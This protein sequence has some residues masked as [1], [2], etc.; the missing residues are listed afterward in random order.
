MMRQQPVG[1]R[2]TTAAGQERASPLAVCT[3]A[4][5]ASR[6]VVGTHPVFLLGAGASVKSGIPGSADM[7]RV[8]LRWLVAGQRNL[9]PDDR[10]I[11]QSDIQEFLAQQ[12]WY[13][14][15]VNLAEF[16]PTVIALLDQPREM[17]RK[18]LLQMISQGTDPSQGYLD[19][20]ALMKRRIVTTV[21][22]P[23]FDELVKIAYG[24][25]GALVTMAN[26]EEYRALTT[27]PR[28]PQLVYLHG[29]AEYYL[30]KNRLE[31]VD[32]LDQVLVDRLLPI[33]RDHPL[34]VIGYRGA[35][36]SL[37]RDL[38]LENVD[39]ADGFKHGIYWCVRGT[40]L[41]QNALP[42]MV[43]ELAHRLGP[44]FTVVP[45]ADFDAVMAE[46]RTAW[47]EQ[48]DRSPGPWTIDRP[49]EDGRF[50]PLVLPLDQRA[51][52]KSDL[53]AIDWNWAA[54]LLAEYARSVHR[55]VPS[56]PDR[57]WCEQELLE[58][59][60]AVHQDGRLCL[61]NGG[62]MLLSRLAR[63]ASPGAW[64]QVWLPG[65]PPTAVDGTLFEQMEGVLEA[66]ESINRPV[67]VKGPRS[68]DQ[69]PYPEEAL[70]E[71]IANALVHRDYASPDPVRVKV[72]PTSVRIENPGGLD[73]SL[74]RRLMGRAYPPNP[75]APVPPDVLQRRIAHGDRGLSLTAYR[76]A[77]VA[78]VFWGIGLVDKLGSGLADAYEAMQVA[79]G[80][81]L[82]EVAG[83]NSSVIVTLTRMPARVDASTGTARPTTPRVRMHTNLLEILSIPRVVWSAPT[84]LRHFPDPGLNRA[85]RDWPRAVPY[86]GRFCTFSDLTDPA[87]PLRAVVD[88][89][90]IR[91]TETHL[92]A[93]D[94]GGRR[95]V[96]LLHETVFQHLARHGLVTDW[97][98]K[99]AYYPCTKGNTR[100]LKYRA[101]VREPERRVAWWPGKSRT[102]CVHKAAVFHIE[103]YGGQ[104][105]LRINPT[106]VFTADGYK[107]RVPPKQATALATAE[108][109]DYF[110]PKVQADVFFWRAVLSGNN[111]SIVLDAGFGAKVIISSTPVSVDVETEPD[112][113]IETVSP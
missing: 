88:L 50:D 86:E 74:L 52:P 26:R 19:L 98:N 68:R 57:T 63:Q 18:F 107:Q 42:D 31:E 102:H 35:E 43:C 66:L 73:Q 106:W 89:N 20:A 56:A 96:H 58:I 45:I 75:G 10:R 28:R 32:H 12:E 94:D 112:I 7:V 62:L 17:R 105:V 44:N 30:D 55:P 67:R 113:S 111:Q 36:R 59:G 87:N 13:R 24:P 82:V 71:V 27:A 48:A 69:R 46:L 109:T 47:E 108:S 84:P 95:V 78:D 104:W 103:Q 76:N 14:P 34:I 53:E 37:M 110:N 11:T 9:H 92:F 99:R 101:R 83:D 2:T 60:L 6:A 54:N 5:L 79:G 22:T 90:D 97:R 85:V 41:A 16:F 38:L 21:V 29:Q 8:A 51:A 81:L 1:D 64:T 49:G 40:A 91:T 39:R 15:G 77:L 80:S 25:G 72:T 3:V 65:K 4:G 100:Y 61:T 70:K 33:L 23:N 93:G